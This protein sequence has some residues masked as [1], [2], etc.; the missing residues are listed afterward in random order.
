MKK[1]SVYKLAKEIDLWN[2]PFDVLLAMV[3]ALFPT[4]DKAKTTCYN[5][6]IGRFPHGWTFKVVNSWYKWSDKK[7]KHEFGSYKIP[8]HCLAAFLEYVVQYKIDP[9]KLYDK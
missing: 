7:Y 5:Y 1:E 6:S 8:A 4:T 3:D 2:T 9:S